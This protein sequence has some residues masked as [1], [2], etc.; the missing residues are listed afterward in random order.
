MLDSK[1]HCMNIFSEI[2][3]VFHRRKKKG[4]GKT[5]ECK[6]WHHFL[7]LRGS[8]SLRV[9]GYMIVYCGDNLHNSFSSFT[10]VE[11][12]AQYKWMMSGSMY[13]YCE[14]N[15]TKWWVMCVC[16]KHV[17]GVA[18]TIPAIQEH[19]VWAASPPFTQICAVCKA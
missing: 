4:V 15:V 17:L 16:K 12:D 13:S 5:R 3:L 11:Q 7:I 19:G 1:Q 10:C 9:P 14:N 2:S 8:V 18:M 6:R